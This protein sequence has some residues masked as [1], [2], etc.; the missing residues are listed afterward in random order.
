MLADCFLNDHA[1]E[2]RSWSEVSGIPVLE[3]V[4][5][6]REFLNALHFDLYIS[7]A[8]YNAWIGALNKQITIFNQSSAIYHYYQ[9]RQ[10]TTS[11]YPSFLQQQQQQYPKHIGSHNIFLLDTA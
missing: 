4:K 1:F 11:I 3:C 7:N 2:M 5:M 9:Q 8:E 10:Q 6:R